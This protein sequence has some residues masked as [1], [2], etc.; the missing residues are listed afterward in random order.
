MKFKLELVGIHKRNN[1]DFLRLYNRFSKTSLSNKSSVLKFE[2]ENCI[3]K[4]STS[5]L[6][7]CFLQFNAVVI[8]NFGFDFGFG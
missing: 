6:M 5:V 2:L 3:I 8:N 7:S 4:L 1:Y